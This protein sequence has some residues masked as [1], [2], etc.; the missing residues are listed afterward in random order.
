MIGSRLFVSTIIFWQLKFCEDG[1]EEE[2]EGDTVNSRLMS[3]REPGPTCNQRKKEREREG[4]M[5][6][7]VS[8]IFSS[9]S[10]LSWLR[11]NIPI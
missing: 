10:I 9:L 3:E 4:E 5:V 1:G 8:V 7:V 2:G 11:E 6:L